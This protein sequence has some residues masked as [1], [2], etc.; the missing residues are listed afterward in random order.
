MGD[1]NLDQETGSIIVL[2]NGDS[3]YVDLNGKRVNKRGYFVDREGNIVLKNGKV[4]FKY[5]EIDYSSGG[6]NGELPEPFFTMNKCKERKVRIEDESEHH[7]RMQL[8]AANKKKKVDISEDNDLG[9]SVRG[10]IGKSNK[11]PSRLYRG[12]RNL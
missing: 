11:S 4:L 5:D 1:F 12:G 3:Q 9:S 7:K 6:A 10:S 2:K 8:I